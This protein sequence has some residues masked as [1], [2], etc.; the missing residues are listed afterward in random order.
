MLDLLIRGF[1]GFWLELIIFEFEWGLVF[2]ELFSFFDMDIF[3][4]L[5]F[6]EFCMMVLIWV[7]LF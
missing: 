5:I 1:D 2:G 7:V 6:V 3:F 4:I